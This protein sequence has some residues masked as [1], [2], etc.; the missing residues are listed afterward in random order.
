V[1]LP[2]KLPPSS[3]TAIP[4]RGT[5]GRQVKSVIPSTGS[6]QAVATYFVGGYY[7]R[8]TNGT[9]TTE[10]K[11]YFAGASRIA[12]RSCRGGTCPAPTY[13]L[14]DHLGSTSI[15]TNASG[16]KISEQRYKPCP[17]GAS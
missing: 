11:Y 9:T 17:Q 10:T 14:G 7:Q 1:P 15:V 2:P 16:A 6:G 12:M 8:T 13:L 5:S 3:M 4:L